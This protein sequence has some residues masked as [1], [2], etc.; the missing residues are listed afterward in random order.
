M[1]SHVQCMKNHMK[2]VNSPN[3]AL[4]HQ[5]SWDTVDGSEIRRL[6][7]DM[8]KYPC[9]HHKVSYIPGESLQESFHFTVSPAGSVFK[10]IPQNPSPVPNV[11]AALVVVVGPNLRFAV[12]QGLKFQGRPGPPEIPRNTWKSPNCTKITYIKILKHWGVV[13][14]HPMYLMLLASSSLNLSWYCYRNHL[15]HLVYSCWFEISHS[16]DSVD[17]S[18]IPNNQLG[19]IKPSKWWNIHYQ[20]RI[21]QIPCKRLKRICHPWIGY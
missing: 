7:V 4:E 18:E 21:I 15:M 11:Q 5:I 10:K 20:L 16:H 19:C 3:P 8:E 1:G 14:G 2:S 12:S 13:D 9:F 6:P 17:G